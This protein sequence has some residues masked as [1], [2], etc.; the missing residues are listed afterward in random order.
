[1]QP[2][3]LQGAQGAAPFSSSNRRQFPY[4]YG[5]AGAP[6]RG[7]NALWDLRGWGAGQGAESGEGCGGTGGGV[8]VLLPHLHSSLRK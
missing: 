5:V 1:M 3:G 8:V 2:L 6:K 7:E 4:Q